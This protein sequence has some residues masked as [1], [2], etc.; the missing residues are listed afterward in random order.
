MRTVGLLV[1][2]GL[3]PLVACSGDKD[4]SDATGDTGDDV[5]G[6]DDDDTAGDGAQLYADY[7]AVC[8]GA[9][10]E[11]AAS[12]PETMA[13][14]LEGLDQAAVEDQ[15]INGGGTMPAVFG[16]TEAE[17]TTVSA[18]VLAEYGS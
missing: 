18:W 7:C 4:G 9:N 5:T 17:A 14:Y 3:S 11:G 8:H 6:D 16:I 1:V 13:V 2:L 10:G 15:V 12:A